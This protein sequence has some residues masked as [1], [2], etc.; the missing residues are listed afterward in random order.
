MTPR[1]KFFIKCFFAGIVAVLLFSWITMLLWNWLVPVLFN[2]RE[3]SFVQALGLLILTKILTFGF[4]GRRH[5]HREGGTFPPWKSRLYEKMSS[6]T[7]EE[8]EA[9]KQKMRDKWCGYSETPKPKE[10]EV[11]ND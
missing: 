8:R 11:S 5:W 6:L 1:G 9:F 7:P 4:G 2:G 3:I 10:G